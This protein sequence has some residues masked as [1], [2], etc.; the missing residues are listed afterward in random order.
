MWELI[1]MLICS[2]FISHIIFWVCITSNVSEHRMML[3]SYLITLSKFHSNWTCSKYILAWCSWEILDKNYGRLFAGKLIQIHTQLT[4]WFICLNPLVLLSFSKLDW[5]TNVEFRVVISLLICRFPWS[6]YQS[7]H[8]YRKINPCQFDIT[9]P[10]T[11][12]WFDKTDMIDWHKLVKMGQSL[13]SSPYPDALLPYNSGLGGMKC[14]YS[15]VVAAMVRLFYNL[16]KWFL[17]CTFSIR[18]RHGVIFECCNLFA[19]NISHYQRIN[20]SI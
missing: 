6:Q 16:S 19:A 1:P 7:F 5:L 17:L 2:L 12:C 11:I 20:L 4:I 18:A 13:Y 14:T 10:S 3:M 15:I 8:R 9:T